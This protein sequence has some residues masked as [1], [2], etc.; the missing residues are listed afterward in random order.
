MFVYKVVWG[1]PIGQVPGLAHTQASKDGVR[2]VSSLSHSRFFH[3]V[4]V[5]LECKSIYITFRTSPLFNPVFTYTIKNFTFSCAAEQ[6]R[7][8][9][10]GKLVGDDPSGRSCY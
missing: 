9:A 8:P 5:C 1:T 3:D 2:G 7:S 4:L 6:N 10:T